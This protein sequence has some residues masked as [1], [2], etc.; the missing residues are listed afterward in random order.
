MPT[1]M[2][3]SLDDESLEQSELRA[4]ITEYDDLY[5]ICMVHQMTPEDQR[6]LNE[7]Y[8]CLELKE[9]EYWDDTSDEIMAIITEGIPFYFPMIRHTLGILPDEDHLY[10]IGD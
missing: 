2:R 4:L 8:E 1:A 6:Y 5:D 3:K 7:L 9:L 10:E